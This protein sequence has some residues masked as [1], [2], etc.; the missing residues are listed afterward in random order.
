MDPW[1]ILLSSGR[2][3]TDFTLSSCELPEKLK[4]IG[5]FA[6]S[7]T[8]YLRFKNGII[9]T[10]HFFKLIHLFQH[11][12]LC[13]FLYKVYICHLDKKTYRIKRI[14]NNTFFINKGQSN[15]NWLDMSIKMCQDITRCCNVCCCAKCQACQMI[16]IRKIVA[17]ITL[18]III[19]TY[20]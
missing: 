13:S 2:M 9:F 10:C 18:F 5:P 15:Q 16:L 14:N 20:P 6:M 1:P 3:T 11:A 8:I 17:S 12:F 19:H 4:N 7:T